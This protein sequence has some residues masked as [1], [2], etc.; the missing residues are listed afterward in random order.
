MEGDGEPA[1][2]R[3][4]NGPG[5]A[6]DACAA[7]DQDPLA[8]GRIEWDRDSGEHRPGEVARELSEKHRLEE[9]ALVDP[10]PTRR[11]GRLHAPAWLSRAGGCEESLAVRQLPG[12]ERVQSPPEPEQPLFGF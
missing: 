10:L 7:R 5:R 1:L 3:V 6:D 12:W 2:V 9:R 11:V 8:V 4:L